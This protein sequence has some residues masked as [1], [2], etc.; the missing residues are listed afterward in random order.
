MRIL[1]LTHRLPYAANRGDRIRALYLLK[2][3][4][5]HHTIDLVSL[6]DALVGLASINADAARVVELRYFGGL[7]IADA[8]I[9]LGV[10]DSTVEREWRYARA[11]LYRALGGTESAAGDTS[12]VD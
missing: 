4:A 12:R 7:T 9:V 5:R 1:F 11:W 10:S 3:L 2:F 6:N 8:A